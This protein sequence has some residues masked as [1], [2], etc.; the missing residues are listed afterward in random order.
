MKIQLNREIYKKES[1]QKT[2]DDYSRLANFNLTEDGNYFIVQ[3]DNIDN[4]VKSVIKDEFCN[5]LLSIK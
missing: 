4:D 3:M 5:Y 1:I 2:I